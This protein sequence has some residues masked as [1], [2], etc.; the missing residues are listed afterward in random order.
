MN[1]DDGLTSWRDLI[2][3]AVAITLDPVIASTLSDYDMDAR[4]DAGHG[5]MEG[6][7]FTAWGEKYVYF[8]VVYD[9][10]EWVGWAPRNP[11]DEV[12]PHVGGQW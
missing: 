9:G 11:C 10:S 7:P 12:T 1:K 6:C 5:S 2:A 3:N 8:P 4:F